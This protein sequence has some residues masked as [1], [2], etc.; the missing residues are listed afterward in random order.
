[1]VGLIPDLFTRFWHCPKQFLRQLTT[2]ASRIHHQDRCTDAGCEVQSVSETIHA[3]IGGGFWWPSPSDGEN[4]GREAILQPGDHC[5]EVSAH[6][7][8]H[9]SNPGKLRDELL[10]GEVFS[11][12]PEAKVLTDAW[13]RHYN[14]RRPHSALGYLSASEAAVALADFVPLSMRSEILRKAGIRVINDCYNANPG[15]VRAALELMAEMS[16]EGRS[17]AVL[18]D[19]LELGEQATALHEDVGR[20]DILLGTGPLSVHTVRAAR[21]A[22]L[23]PGRTGHFDDRDS[24]TRRLKSTTGAGDLVLIKASRGMALEHIAK[25]L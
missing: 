6:A 12:V 24:L 22:G 11:S 25:A 5:A 1:M 3:T 19:M 13:R 9:Q 16:V 8:T 10:N 14:H 21:E 18:G 20:V 17:I 7:A 15:S 4:H 2:I 23:E